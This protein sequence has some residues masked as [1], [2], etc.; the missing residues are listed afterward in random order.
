MSDDTFQPPHVP[1]HT[2]PEAY[3]RS[4]RR[5]AAGSMIGILAAQIFT[6]LSPEM[7]MIQA[8]MLTSVVWVLGAIVGA[9]MG[10]RMIERGF[11]KQ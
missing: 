1:P 2:Q 5:M 7:T 9:Y 10:F 11:G 6:F 8:E 4:R 3:W